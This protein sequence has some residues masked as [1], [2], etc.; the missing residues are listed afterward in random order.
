MSK[1]DL[2]FSNCK[3]K[4][5]VRRVLNK[6]EELEIP[7]GLSRK[8]RS[9]FVKA[10]DYVTDYQCFM[11]EG[12]WSEYVLD[13]YN[14]IGGCKMF[15]RD[16]EFDLCFDGGLGHQL[17]SYYYGHCGHE[18]KLYEWARELG[19]VYEPYANWSGCVYED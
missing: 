1:H 8:V 12:P 3:S 5:D 18:E 16:R 14:G 15:H 13:R 11:H 9:F 4:A 7:T 6:Q 17:W 2:D 19:L 10:R